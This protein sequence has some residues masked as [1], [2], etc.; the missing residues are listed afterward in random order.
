MFLPR[1]ADAPEPRFTGTE[2]STQI[3]PFADDIKEQQRKITDKGNLNWLAFGG[4]VLILFVVS[5]ATISYGAGVLKEPIE[6][7]ILRNAADT[8]D[9]KANVLSRQE[10]KGRFVIVDRD[11]ERLMTTVGKLADASA[12][13]AEVADRLA[14]IG[15]QRDESF[16]NL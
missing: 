2:I 1:P 10:I 9:V 4:F 6:K 14:T 3:G 5:M 7:A 12:T 13:R 11:I 15:K 16:G 8:A